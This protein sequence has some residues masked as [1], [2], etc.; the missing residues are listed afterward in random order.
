MDRLIHEWQK[1]KSEDE[2]SPISEGISNDVYVTD[3]FVY[4]HNKDAQ[5]HLNEFSIMEELYKCDVKVPKPSL[6]SEEHNITVYERINGSS[7]SSFN[8]DKRTEV[9]EKIGECFR[10]FHDNQDI[11]STTN[12]ININ[13]LITVHDSYSSVR[14]SFVQSA[15]QVSDDS[16][17][18][19]LIVKCCEK[20]EGF[21]SEPKYE[22][23]ILH[24]DYH[25]GNVIYSN[26]EIRIIDFEHAIV[27][28]SDIDLVHAFIRLRGDNNEEFTK[29]FI[30]GYGKEIHE[31]EKQYICIGFL[32]E[33]V[34]ARWWEKEYDKNLEGRYDNLEDFLYEYIEK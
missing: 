32:H 24:M 31:I 8:Q 16:M 11:E 9:A 20:L 3:E 30:K 26:G 19:D 14:D 10:G 5:R 34:S 28:H 33:C 1:I 18:K 27:S 22:K 29:N 13:D 4:K 17:F 7:V 2:L 6:S 15:E 12:R 25:N 23:S 21:E